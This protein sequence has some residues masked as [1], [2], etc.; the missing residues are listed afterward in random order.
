MQIDCQIPSLSSQP[1]LHFVS[2][3][4]V[5]STHLIVK[6]D[7]LNVSGKTIRG[8]NFQG[9]MVSRYAYRRS[10]F[11]MDLWFWFWLHRCSKNC[12]LLR[13]LVRKICQDTY[14]SAGRYSHHAHQQAFL[15][16]VSRPTVFRLCFL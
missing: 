15:N 4:S 14:Y 6:K 10:F 1:K 13:S 16:F 2:R 12:V 7:S 5:N 8:R 9:T 3:F 11:K